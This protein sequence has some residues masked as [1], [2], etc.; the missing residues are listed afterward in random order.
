MSLFRFHVHVPLG[1][2]AEGGV[3]G[4]KGGEGGGRV[5]AKEE[6]SDEVA[7]SA[8]QVGIIKELH[9][10]TEI[11]ATSSNPKDSYHP[12][13]TVAMYADIFV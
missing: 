4:G 6:R 2:V 12:I 5:K 7:H 10:V 1:L 3:T 13:K 9:E 8:F 11:T